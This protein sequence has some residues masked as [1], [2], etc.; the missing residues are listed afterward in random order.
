MV[1]PSYYI[2]PNY[3]PNN[4]SQGCGLSPALKI[5]QSIIKNLSGNPNVDM[6]LTFHHTPIRD[7]HPD[8]LKRK[9]QCLV[10]EKHIQIT[11]N[12]ESSFVEACR[13]NNR[14]ENFKKRVAEVK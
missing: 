4:A 5:S 12:T 3:N 6:I 2:D 10:S 9:N 8:F 14:W 1:Y 11:E 7:H 13:S